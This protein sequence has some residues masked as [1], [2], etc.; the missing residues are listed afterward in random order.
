MSL[1]TIVVIVPIIPPPSMRGILP[2]LNF[3]PLSPWRCRLIFSAS[4]RSRFRIIVFFINQHVIKEAG[5]NSRSYPPHQYIRCSRLGCLPL[6]LLFRQIVLSVFIVFNDVWELANVGQN[7]RTGPGRN[8]QLPFQFCD[9]FV[10]THIPKSKVLCTPPRCV[11]RR[12][13]AV[14]IIDVSGEGSASSTKD[15]TYP[16]N[17]HNLQKHRFDRHK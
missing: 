2:L 7:V 6:T 12:G 1:V 16:K 3:A 5:C 17:L 9:D 4:L 11:N 13:E 14:N 10:R 8:T 15:V